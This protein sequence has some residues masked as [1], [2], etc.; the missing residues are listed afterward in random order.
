[1]KYRK[2]QNLDVEKAFNTYPKE[3]MDKLLLIRQFIFQVAEET[4]VIG[5]IEE[6]LKWGNPAYL[7]FAPKTGTTIRLSTLRSNCEKF[8]ISVHCQTTLITEFKKMYPELNYE[9]NRSLILEAN[10]TLPYEAIKKFLFL[11][12]TY[13]CQKK[14][15]IE[16]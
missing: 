2:F 6:T 16:I 14:H 11:A 12:L 7:T 9:K 1:M 10:N 8:T 3:V 13:H 15:A 5:S 4:N